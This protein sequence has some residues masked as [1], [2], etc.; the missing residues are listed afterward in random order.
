VIGDRKY[1][2]AESSEPLIDRVALHAAHLE[3]IHPRS[4]NN[5]SVDC[6]LPADFQHLLREL[7]RSK[8]APANQLLKKR[9]KR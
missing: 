5:I 8:P 3:F 7:A 9:R 6:K 4:G 2:R 1:R